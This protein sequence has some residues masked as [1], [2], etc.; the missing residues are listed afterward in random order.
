M[1][2]V[3]GR[4]LA[5]WAPTANKGTITVDCNRLAQGQY[6]FVMKQDEQVLKNTKLIKN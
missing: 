4:I 1:I 6:L 2:D 3:L 5:Q